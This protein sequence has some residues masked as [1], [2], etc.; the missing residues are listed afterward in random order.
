MQE[1]ADSTP[2][3]W[4]ETLVDVPPYE[5]IQ[6]SAFIWICFIPIFVC[7]C[8]G[9]IDA[10]SS[11]YFDRNHSQEEL[12]ELPPEVRRGNLIDLFKKSGNQMVRSTLQVR[13][14]VHSQYNHRSSLKICFP[15]RNKREIEG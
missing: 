12:K 14:C 1:P 6:T 4:N 13:T 10:I 5:V 8:L 9:C 3:G 2:T 7:I 11:Y 15:G